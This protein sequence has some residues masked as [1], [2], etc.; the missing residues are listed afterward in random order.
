[1]TR[2]PAEPSVLHLAVLHPPG[3]HPQF[4]LL[5]KIPSTHP[6]HSS[7][8]NQMSQAFQLCLIPSQIHLESSQHKS[9]NINQQLLL[10]Q[11]KDVVTVPLTKGCEE[12]ALVHHTGP[13]SAWDVPWG[14]LPRLRQP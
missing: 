14:N 10:K 8:L 12:D 1:M 11:P 3:K 13:D 4:F 9:T 6:V 2:I 5:L 7:A